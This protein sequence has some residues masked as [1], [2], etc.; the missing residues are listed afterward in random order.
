[1]FNVKRNQVFQSTLS[2]NRIRVRGVTP[3]KKDAKQSLVEIVNIDSNG[4]AIKD[5][6][7]VV[8]QDS[9]RRWYL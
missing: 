2:D 9:I 4:R 6:A 7:R 1:M 5:T 3:N 8:F